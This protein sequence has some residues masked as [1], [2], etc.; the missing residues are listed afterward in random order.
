[1]V[2]SKPGTQPESA[3]CSGFV[4]GLAKWAGAGDPSGLK[5][6]GGYTGTL[7]SHCNHISVDVARMGDLVLSRAGDGVSRCSHHGTPTWK[8]FLVCESRPPG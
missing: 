4:S 2:E 3:D 5:Y 8:R 7:L 6:T 1:M